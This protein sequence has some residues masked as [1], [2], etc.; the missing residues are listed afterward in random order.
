[1]PRL[2]RSWRSCERIRLHTIN[3]IGDWNMKYRQYKTFDLKKMRPNVL[4][5]GNGL[6][7]DTT[8]SWPKLI[9]GVCREGRDVSKYEK[10]E[11]GRFYVPNTVLTLATSIVEDSPRRKQYSEIFKDTKYPEC[12]NIQNLL[13]MPFD[14]VLTTNYTYELEAALNPS[15]PGSSVETKRKYAAVTE[16]K[17]DA[18]YLIHTFNSVRPDSPDIWHIH[19]ELRC[20]NSIILSHDEYARYTYRIIEYM[21][22]R[23]NSYCACE[24]ALNFQS[25]IDYFIL[26][27][28][29][30]L[31]LSMD[32]A[33]FDLWWLL[34]RRLREKAPCGRI[35]F[36]EARK[37]ENKYK[38]MALIDSGVEV[39]TC[40]MIGEKDIDYNLFYGKAIDDIKLQI[41]KDRRTIHV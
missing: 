26:G 9:K 7:Y 11:K 16:N 27:N 32:F 2:R 33:E 28:V 4:V 21:K 13:Q 39:E 31:G 14:A 37:E 3:D 12:D 8:I 36:Y 40:G 30:I 15:Y 24:Q 5:L 18:K 29:Y 1:M 25:W 10:G 20:P 6:I 35:I 19:G 34:S 23:G 22:S 41:A 17:S 38:Q